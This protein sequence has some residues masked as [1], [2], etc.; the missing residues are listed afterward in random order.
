MTRV[1][2]AP[3]NKY[4]SVSSSYRTYTITVE[5]ENQVSQVIV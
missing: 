2:V 5:G 4:E 3:A 1:I